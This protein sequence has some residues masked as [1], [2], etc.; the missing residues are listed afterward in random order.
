MKAVSYADGKVKFSIVP[1]P[2]GEGV[3]V[4][5][6]LQEYAEV[7]CICFS[8]NPILLMWPGMKYQE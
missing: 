3:I 7:T 5:L 8:Q 2:I 4:M 6:H 1:R